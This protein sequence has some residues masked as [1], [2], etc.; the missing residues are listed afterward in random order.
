M[1]T[2]RSS[3]TKWSD[4]ITDVWGVDPRALSA[5]RMG[6][7]T[8]LLADLAG[9]SR[10]FVA[11]YTDGGALPRVAL[12][13]LLGGVQP[14]L[15]ALSGHPAWQATLFV[16]AAVAAIALLIGYRTRGATVVSAAMLFSLHHANPF[17]LTAGDR[18]LLLL[19]FWGCLLPL[20]ST[21]SLD[22]RRNRVLVPR[23]HVFNVATAGVLIQL[24]AVYLVSVFHKTGP[25]WRSDFTALYYALNLEVYTTPFGEWVGSAPFVLLQAGTLATLVLEAFGPLLA[26]SPFRPGASRTVAALTFIGFHGGLIATMDLGLFPYVCIVGWLVV[27]P[28]AFWGWFG[29]QFGR[30]LALSG[31]SDGQR[32]SLSSLGALSP[33][34]SAFATVLILFSAVV[35]WQEVDPRGSDLVL[36]PTQPILARVAYQ[37][38]VY[39]NWTMFSPNPSR[40]DVWYEVT[41]TT[42][43]GRRGRVVGV[44]P[45]DSSGAGYET[46][47][48]RKLLMKH[49]AS[50][51]FAPHRE[52]YAAFVWADWNRQHPDDPLRALEVILVR[53]PTPAWGEVTDTTRTVL[54]RYDGESVLED[55]HGLTSSASARTVLDFAP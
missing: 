2:T 12:D 36:G 26:L 21:A 35:G 30:W 42:T 37:M 29:V 20:G 24:Y 23:G 52:H 4:L 43:G 47:H 28:T 14:S 49:Y 40:A 51:R 10:H 1:M 33:V 7:G 19:L 16:A 13:E 5:F 38:G 17:V 45:R 39:Q 15:H 41:A 27:L 8:L 48:W 53:E 34:R 25:T 55:G 22:A 32:I 3:G 54:V 44:G 31:Q 6:L 18:L 11:H 9:R 46:V 50:D